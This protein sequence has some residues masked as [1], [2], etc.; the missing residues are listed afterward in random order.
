MKLN[1][2]G[3]IC[4]GIGSILLLVVIFPFTLTA[5]AIKSLRKRY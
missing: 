5:V 2:L 1:Q 4:C 3:D